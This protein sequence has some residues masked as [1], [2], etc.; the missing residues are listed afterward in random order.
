MLIP[1]YFVKENVFLVG[2]LHTYLMPICAN[3]E[4]VDHFSVVKTEHKLPCQGFDLIK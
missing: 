4:V 1:N 2:C 3:L